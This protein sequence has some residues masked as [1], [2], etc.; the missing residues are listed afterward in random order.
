MNEIS[1][2][3]FFVTELLSITD[4]GEMISIH[5]LEELADEH[6]IVEYIRD[7]FGLKNPEFTPENQLAIKKLVDNIYISEQD[8]QKYIIHN[9]GLTY[10]IAKLV[11]R[12]GGIAYDY[13]WNFEDNN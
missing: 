5:Q 10:L 4:R 1:Q 7:N 2:I 11:E 9:N 6:K 12:L 13:K 8:A 3:Q